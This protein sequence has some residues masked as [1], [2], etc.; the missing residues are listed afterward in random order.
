[1]GFRHCTMLGALAVGLAARVDLGEPI[2]DVV[3]PEDPH[4]GDFHEEHFTPGEDAE[5]HEWPDDEEERSH[6]PHVGSHGTGYIPSAEQ[7]KKLERK[8]TFEE[9]MLEEMPES[10]KSELPRDW[11][12]KHQGVM[13]PVED[14]GTCGSCWAF[15]ASDALASRFAVKNNV[16]YDLSEKHILDC[17][18]PKRNGC[19]GGWMQNA[20]EK[21][22]KKGVAKR[23]SYAPYNGRDQTCPSDDE[24]DRKGYERVAYA[25]EDL[26][27]G[28]VHEYYSNIEGVKQDLYKFGPCSA[29]VGADYKFTGKNDRA[30][31]EGIWTCTGKTFINHAITLVGW[32]V[33]NE[34]KDYWI[35]KNSY[36]EEWGEKGYGKVDMKTCKLGDGHGIAVLCPEA[37]KFTP[38]HFP[39]PPTTPEDG[40][41][42]V[43]VFDLMGR[44]GLETVKVGMPAVTATSPEY[45][46]HREEWMSFTYRVPRNR[47]FVIQFTNGGDGRVVFF[48]SSWETEIRHDKKFKDW[49]CGKDRQRGESASKYVKRVKACDELK[50]GV[51]R[52]NLVYKFKVTNDVSAPTDSPTYKPT[53]APTTAAPT[54]QPT[55]AP[56]LPGNFEYVG[57]GHCDH[58]Y[59]AGWK[60]EDATLDKCAMKC[61]KETKCLY[62]SLKVGKSC[63]RYDKRAKKCNRTHGKHDHK[64]WKKP[65][66]LWD[67]T[68]RP[69]GAPTPK[70]THP[71]T[72]PPTRAPTAPTES[73][74]KAPTFPPT[75][76]PTNHV[77]CTTYA[78]QELEA[79][80]KADFENFK[81]NVYTATTDDICNAYCLLKPFCTGWIRQPSKNKCWLV[82]KKGKISW[83]PKEDSNGGLRCYPG[84][85]FQ[86]MG[87][88][89]CVPLGDAVS[90]RFMEGITMRECRWECLADPDCTGV[91]YDTSEICVIH[92]GKLD[93]RLT[94]HKKQFCWL[95]LDSAGLAGVY[96][97]KVGNKDTGEKL[98]IDCDGTATQGDRI[99]DRM[100]F[101][102]VRPQ[103]PGPPL[104]SMVIENVGDHPTRKDIECLWL[105]TY[106]GTDQRFIQGMGWPV[107]MMV[108]YELDEALD[109]STFDEMPEPSFPPTHMSDALPLPSDP[110]MEPTYHKPPTFKPTI[111]PTTPPPTPRP[112]PQPTPR[113][114]KAPTPLPTKPPTNP[115]TKPVNVYEGKIYQIKAKHGRCL[116]SPERNKNGKELYM[117]SCSTTNKDQQWVYDPS[118]AQLKLKYGKCMDSPGR[119]NKRG[120]KVQTWSCSTTNKNQ[121]W[122]FDPK[123][124]QIK[125]KHGK[126]LDAK[127]RNKNKG[128]VHMW[129]CNTN[130]KNQQWELKEIKPPAPKPSVSADKAYDGKVYHLKAK[131]GRC[132]DSPDRNKNGGKLHMWSCSDKS[133]NQQWLYDP[134]SGQLKMNYG[135]CLDTPDKGKKKGGK[136]HVWECSGNENHQAWTFDKKTGQIK[137]KKGNK[138]LDAKDRNKNGGKVH[139]WN[140]NTKYKN[141]QWELKE[142][143][144]VSVN[145]GKKA[146]DSFTKLGGGYCTKGYYSGWKKQDATLDKCA[147]KCKSE[148]KCKFFALKKGHT[149]SRYDK[150]A[151][152][153]PR[154]HGKRDHVAYKKN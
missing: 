24:F 53:Y 118:T 19:R 122:I 72:E 102:D 110:T 48:R 99:H 104:A 6:W 92:T 82:L 29:V 14:Q 45:K 148:A 125:A 50:N 43:I 54:M 152:S 66:H 63:S 57:K 60:K 34:G 79:W 119:G 26:M 146:I 16:L 27:D 85:G 39:A 107:F 98:T 15:S 62:F 89:A 76:R 68:F 55:Y 75:P 96:T 151:G 88:G 129:S 137:A 70:P 84:E 33:S 120:A 44:T 80:K 111:A 95:R 7:K 103:C 127:H 38:D 11:N 144:G 22:G 149:C 23:T 106:T 52:D 69:T 130:N 81:R 73:P 105:G 134:V 141:Q 138:C 108:K 32:G 4:E 136:V 42:P 86:L 2:L 97:Y 31:P 18:Y 5:D 61:L 115:P 154:K 142:L 30:N 94:K 90:Q 121:M 17:T 3:E 101:D 20:W 132:L 21:V 40:E 51:L 25:G 87:E 109:C 56:T 47:D 117:Y 9:Y 153:C 49:K 41:G 128:K 123:T 135:K 67:N 65:E 36:G 13:N 83:T 116:H 59:Y 143:K 8:E 35:I 139:M 100:H 74:T 93:W 91:E 77:G 140:C 114:T 145:D 46:L 1:M 126:C 28:K 147:E 124:G 64:T 78:G 10:M 113:P 12:W 71:P 131:H 58:G 133:K 150:R 112:T 37:R